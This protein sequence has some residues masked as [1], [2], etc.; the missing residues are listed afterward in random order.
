MLILQQNIDH[1]ERFLVVFVTGEFEIFE[2]NSRNDELLWVEGEK[3]REH[4]SELTGCDYNASLGL[5][6][7]ADVKGVIRLWNKDKKFLREIVF[8]TKI[9]SIAFLNSA[10]DILVSHAERVSKILLAEYWTKTF[11]Y[12]GITKSSENPALT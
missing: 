1:T 7:T 9:D 2:L 3:A 8:P 10:G 11:D 4:D 5:I 6:V 12:Y